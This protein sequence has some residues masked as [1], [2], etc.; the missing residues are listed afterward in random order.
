MN[1]VQFHTDGACIAS[2]SADRT[3]KMWDIRS[4]QLIQV[5][6]LSLS[7]SLSLRFSPHGHMYSL[8]AQTSSL[9]TEHLMERINTFSV[10]RK[11]RIEILYLRD[12]ILFELLS[13]I[14]IF[15]GKSTNT[16]IYSTVSFTTRFFLFSFI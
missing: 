13:I 8:L 3:I 9:V 15:V 2:G 11:M 14:I 1:C 16:T 10:L 4:H 6:S 12:V 7:L 5:I